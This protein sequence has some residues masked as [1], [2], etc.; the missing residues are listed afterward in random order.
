MEKGLPFLLRRP[1]SI[2][3][4][5]HKKEKSIHFEQVSG[6]ILIFNKEFLKIEQK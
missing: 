5:L 1:I 2:S 4:I 6:Q 3:K